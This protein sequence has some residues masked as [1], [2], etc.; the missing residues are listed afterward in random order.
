M[1]IGLSVWAM[2]FAAAGEALAFDAR[3]PADVLAVLTTN[4]ASGDLKKD[5]KGA[6]YIEAKA[7]PLA[8]EVD[9]LDCNSQGTNCGS[10]LYA[11]GWN[12]TNLS[13][14]QINRWNRLTLMCPA[15][16]TSEDHPHAWY[17]LR[18]SKNE[19]RADVVAE[20][21]TWLDCLSDFDKFTDAP[22]EY[23][24]AHE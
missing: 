9:F 13:L 12:M 3:D 2:G 15:Y 18:P 6:P 1:M 17:G 14:E 20:L 24:K 10:V 5:D 7:G 11:T 16:L 4:G 22:D 19:T 21:N 23:L 8:F